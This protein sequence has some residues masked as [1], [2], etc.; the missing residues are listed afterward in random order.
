MTT[1]KKAAPAVDTNTDATATNDASESGG[2]PAPEEVMT[3]ATISKAKATI[4]VVLKP[5]VQRQIEVRI[6]GDSLIVHAWG[7]KALAEMLQAQQMT[8]EEKKLAKNNRA[9]K[10]PES[11]FQEARYLINGKDCFPSTGFKKAMV[12]AGFML[13]IPKAFIRAGIR[14]IGDFVTIEHDELKRREDFVNVGKWPNKVADLRYRPEYKNWRATLNILYREDMFDASQ[15]VSLL[16]NAGFSVG[17]GEWR[18]QKDGQH[19]TFSVVT[20]G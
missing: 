4:S 11:D 9:K 20:Q 6:E 2:I 3:A 5:I 7:K 12:D 14:V 17:V 10:D 15:V 1:K 16:S 18:P 13:G 19:G 8:K